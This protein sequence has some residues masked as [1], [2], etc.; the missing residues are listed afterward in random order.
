METIKFF[1]LLKDEVDKLE[2]QVQEKLAE[3]PSGATVDARVAL[4]ICTLATST[5]I[6]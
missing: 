2:G 4:T 5:G 3:D 6:K 1:N